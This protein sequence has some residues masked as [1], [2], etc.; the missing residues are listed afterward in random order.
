MAHLS[1]AFADTLEVDGFVRFLEHEDQ[2]LIRAK[3]LL[4]PRVLLYLMCILEV[5][6]GFDEDGFIGECYSEV[7]VVLMLDRVR[8]LID[9]EPETN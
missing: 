9:M 7:G 6:L 3:D 2:L 1:A 5:S 8:N 4:D